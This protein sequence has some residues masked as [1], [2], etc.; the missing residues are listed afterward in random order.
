MSTTRVVAPREPYIRTG[1]L[2][3]HPALARAVEEA[4]C[5]GTGFS[6]TYFWSCLERITAEL[7][8][9]VESC[10]A[11]RDKMQAQVDEFYQAKAATGADFTSAQQRAE[12]RAFLREIGYMDPDGGSVSVT[13]QFVDP[14]VATIPA[15]QLLVPLDNVR[16]LINAVN[17][18]W[19][20]LYDALRGFDVIPDVG[21]LKNKIG[22]AHV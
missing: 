20:S 9:E 19:G 22:R 3:V 10:L 1:G 4:I 18:R 11:F 21:M 13:T 14:E 12:S 17:A 16:Y 7:R 15:P 5:P 2:F 6:P 8:P